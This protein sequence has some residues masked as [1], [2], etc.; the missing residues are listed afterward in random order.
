MT[1]DVYIFV[2]MP[3]NEWLTDKIIYR[4]RLYN[5]MDQLC[6]MSGKI[7]YRYIDNE[8]DYITIALLERKKYRKEYNSIYKYIKSK[9]KNCELMKFN[10]SFNINKI[11]KED[12]HDKIVIMYF[13][14][15]IYEIILIANIC[16]M[17]S[18]DYC[19]SVIMVNNEYLDSKLERIDAWSLQRAYDTMLKN[20]WPVNSDI[21]FS[22]GWSWHEKYLSYFDGFSIN[23]TSRAINA[24][25]RIFTFDQKA[26]D[27]SNELLWAMIGIESLLANGKGGI[28]DQIR[29]NLS[30]LFNDS[31]PHI[32]KIINNMYS[33]RSRFV[34]GDIDFQS[35][36]YFFDAADRF[37]KY[38]DEQM[39]T[40]DVSIAI[41][42]STLQYIINKN[43]SGIKFKSIVENDV[44][45]DQETK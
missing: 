34:H 20:K 9:Q 26:Q 12:Y 24:L 5:M 23:K 19:N 35:F 39:E 11:K 3:E 25:S 4:E 15:L 28:L 36:G 10:L 14:K 18:I 43:W 7:K 38:T 6:E 1:I 8:I 31:T 44:T 29:E 41:L 22:D 13:S 27:Y 45:I 40:V 17:G 2:A 30:I 16:M 42:V 21:K 32:R 37:I 33:Y